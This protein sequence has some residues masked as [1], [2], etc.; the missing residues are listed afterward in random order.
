MAADL[1]DKVAF[2]VR[3]GAGGTGELVVEW[4]VGREGLGFRGPRQGVRGLRRL[5]IQ[6]KGSRGF[7]EQGHQAKAQK[8]QSP[9][10]EAEQ[11]L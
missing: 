2:C 6:T 4:E 3:I 11:G 10:A 7:S 8:N 5:R 1:K 9:P